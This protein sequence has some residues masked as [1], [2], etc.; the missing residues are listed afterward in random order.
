MRRIWYALTVAAVA[1]LAAPPAAGPAFAQSSRTAATGVPTVAPDDHV[2]G[3]KDAPVT[4]IEYAS[5]T[6]P[7]CAA[8]DKETLPQI[9][10]DWIEPG[11][12][13]LIYRNFPFD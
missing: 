2:L 7:H 8:F 6:C 13:K 4:I 12:A 11:K 3:N 5:M 1:A 10:K 9:K